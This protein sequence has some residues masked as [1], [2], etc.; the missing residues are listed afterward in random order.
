MV[1]PRAGTP[2]A[3]PDS[4]WG[5]GWQVFA[6]P[7]TTDRPG[8]WVKN[9]GLPGTSSLMFQGADGTTWAYILNEN[10]GDAVGTADQPFATQIKADIQAAIAA[11]TDRSTP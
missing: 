5:L 8:N 6:A 7:N 11:W 1:D 10:D 2:I 9:G 4:W 3:G